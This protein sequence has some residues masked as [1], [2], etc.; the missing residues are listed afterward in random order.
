MTQTPNTSPTPPPEEALRAEN[1]S[2]KAALA[3]TSRALEVW[4]EA[5]DTGRSEPLFVARDHARR[6]MAD[7]IVLGL[8][9][10][11]GGHGS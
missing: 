6:V 1:G 3:Q 4:Q 7:L 10:Q 8:H 5:M 9:P 2:L 11:E